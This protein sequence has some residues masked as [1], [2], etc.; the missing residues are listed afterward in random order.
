MLA[1]GFRR[2][3]AQDYFVWRLSCQT[4]L[5]P[6]CKENKPGSRKMKKFVNTLQKQNVTVTAMCCEV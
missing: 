5:T 3:D 4:R 1:K 6:T 2:T